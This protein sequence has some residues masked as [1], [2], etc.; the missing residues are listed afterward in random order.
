MGNKQSSPPGNKQSLPPSPNVGDMPSLETSSVSSSPVSSPSPSP[1]ESNTNEEEEEE[2]TNEVIPTLVDENEHEYEQQQQQE[3]QPYTKIAI[4]GTHQAR[5]R[6]FLAKYFS[7]LKGKSK[8]KYKKDTIERFANGAIVKFVLQINK[9]NEYRYVELLYSGDFKNTKTKGRKYYITREKNDKDKPNYRKNNR[10]LLEQNLD[11]TDYVSNPVEHTWMHDSGTYNEEENERIITN[12]LK[13]MDKERGYTNDDVIVFDPIENDPSLLNTHPTD[14]TYI[15]YFIRH[16]EGEHNVASRFKKMNLIDPELTEG[17]VESTIGINKA[18]LKD[19]EKE[20]K[21]NIHD[22]HVYVFSSDLYRT[23][24]TLQY[25]IYGLD[26]IFKNMDTSIHVLPC[27]HELNYFNSGEC[28]KKTMISGNE[29]KSNCKTLKYEDKNQQDTYGCDQVLL[30]RNPNENKKYKRY[31]KEIS[32]PIKDSKIWNINWKYYNEFYKG[33]RR[34]PS[35][36][37]KYCKDTNMVEQ[38]LE[39]MEGKSIMKGARKK[40]RKTRKRKKMKKIKMK[41]RKTRKR[42]MKKN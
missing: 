1:S 32:D 35:R 14:H 8:G 25:S 33:T 27:S 22:N 7:S 10:T 29:N 6:C 37:R 28:D 20:K 4:V 26:Q 23:R 11:K 39:I 13:I 5:L 15:F 24:E 2:N 18:L 31:K 19:I 17:G 38:A 30:V 34:K 3:Q 21:K 12:V 9:V 41:K 36:K 42:K 16:G 40:K